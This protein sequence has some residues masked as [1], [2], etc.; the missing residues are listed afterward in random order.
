MNWLLVWII[1]ITSQFFIT[2]IV[3]A[4]QTERNYT[5]RNINTITYKSKNNINKSSYQVGRVTKVVSSKEGS[6]LFIE[7]PDSSELRFYYSGNSLVKNEQ[8]LV[9]QKNGSHFLIEASDPR[10]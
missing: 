6:I 5:D 10:R 8:V 4:Q 1:L 2:I 7:L 3:I 9:Y